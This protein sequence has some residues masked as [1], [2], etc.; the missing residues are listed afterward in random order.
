LFVAT[1]LDEVSGT[2]TWTDFS[3][4]KTG[5]FTARGFKFKLVA[6]STDSD[7]QFN[8]SALSISVDMPDRVQ[9]ETDVVSSAGTKS[10]NFGDSFFSIPSVGITANDMGSGD[11]FTIASKTITGF[12]VTFYNSSAVAVSRTFNYQA[13][14]Y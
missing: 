11:Y 5:D 13:R 12:D 2:P 1:T 3:K 8:V 6:S 14:G 9:G 7:H 4:F 10:V